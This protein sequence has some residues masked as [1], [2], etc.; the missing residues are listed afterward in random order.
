MWVETAP[1]ESPAY[2]TE[3]PSECQPPSVKNVIKCY[4]TETICDLGL[5]KGKN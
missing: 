5:T 4:K 3:G 1:T 2:N